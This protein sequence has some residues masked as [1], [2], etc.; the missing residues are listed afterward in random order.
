MVMLP[1][2]WNKNYLQYQLCK[3]QWARSQITSAFRWAKSLIRTS[4][5]DLSA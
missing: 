4:K 1:I 2:E 3:W 5:L